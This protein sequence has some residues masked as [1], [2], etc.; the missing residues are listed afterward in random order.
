MPNVSSSVFNEP[1]PPYYIQEPFE[2]ITEDGNNT[3]YTDFRQVVNPQWLNWN[4]R[5]NT[6]AASPSTTTEDSMLYSPTA[7]PATGGI[8]GAISGALHDSGSVTTTPDTPATA[9]PTATTATATA[10]PTIQDTTGVNVQL[11]RDIRQQQAL[12]A[13]NILTKTGATGVDPVTGEFDPSKVEMLYDPIDFTVKDDELRTDQNKLLDT[14]PERA[15]LSDPEFISNVQNVATPESKV[16]FFENIER[17]YSDL[18]TAV[19]AQ[20][21]ISSKDVIDPSQIVD[22]RTK[23]QMFERGSLADAKTQDLIKEATTAYQIEQLTNGIESG[24]FPPWAAPTVRKANEIMNQRGLGASS[25]A[26]AAVAQAIME[27]AIPIAA[28]DAQKYAT[29]QIQNLN[30]EQQTA[31][32]NA[33]TISAMDRQNLDNRLKAAQQ[34]AQSFLQMNLQNVSQKQAAA[35]LSYQSRVQSLFTDQAAENARKQ[36]NATSQNQVINF[37]ISLE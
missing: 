9:D 14:G 37:T 26:A 13:G 4:Q 35:I 1:E 30:N 16:S 8:G 25:M 5:K 29:I 7:T 33:A 22:E 10:T 32:A 6:A 27:S 2:N 3:V 15:L 28:N 24:K 36:F 17:T 20:G 19:A 18:P 34:N 21:E 11:G 12:G 31:L 23:Q